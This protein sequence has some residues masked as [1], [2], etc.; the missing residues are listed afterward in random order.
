MLLWF[1][2]NADNVRYVCK[3]LDAHGAENPFLSSIDVAGLNYRGFAASGG[4][5]SQDALFADAVRFYD[6][7]APQYD[8]L[9]LLGRS[10][11][12]GVAAS[13]STVRNASGA[14]LIT[15]YESVTRLAKH[16]FGWLGAHYFVKNRFESAKFWRHNH[17]PAAILEVINDRVIPNSHTESLAAVISDLR[18]HEKV[19]SCTH[20]SITNDARMASFIDRALSNFDSKESDV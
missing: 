15:P 19:G 7:L 16:Y 3:L 13:L 18:L 4:K 12:T 5:P 8:R 20:A 1:D 2:G 17:T 9:F 10:L 6:A 11:G 14:V